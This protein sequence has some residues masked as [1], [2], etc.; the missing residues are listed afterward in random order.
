M[1]KLYVLSIVCCCSLK[2]H[3]DFCKKMTKC[4]NSRLINGKVLRQGCSKWWQFSWLF[5]SC[6]VRQ[7]M[8]HWVLSCSGVNFGFVK[9]ESKSLSRTQS[10][11]FICTKVMHTER[12]IKF[13]HSAVGA[14]L[15]FIHTRRHIYKPL[16]SV[17][18]W[19]VGVEFYSCEHCLCQGF[20]A[21]PLFPAPSGPRLHFSNQAAKTW[22]MVSVSVRHAASLLWEGVAGLFGPITACCWGNADGFVSKRF[23]NRG[24]IRFDVAS[25]IQTQTGLRPALLL[26]W[27]KSGRSPLTLRSY[28]HPACHPLTPPP[29]TKPARRLLKFTRFTEK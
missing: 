17:C 13:T 9:T 21:A 23:N 14:S 19:R 12:G 24:G 15:Q 28:K 27:N 6:V 20:S 2:K 4:K 8:I 11:T 26:K 3:N 29:V 18:F 22:L 7:Y 1:E 5:T 10:T 25:L 16:L